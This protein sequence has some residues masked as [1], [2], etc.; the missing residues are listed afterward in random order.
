MDKNRFTITIND[1]RGIK[2]YHLHEIMKKVILYAI[3]GLGIIFASGGFFI[4][5]LNPMSLLT[6]P[7]ITRPP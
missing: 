7:H 4:Y 5:Y 1:S 6:S 3:I 2:Q